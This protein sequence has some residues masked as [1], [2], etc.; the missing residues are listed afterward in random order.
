MATWKEQQGD[1]AGIDV[2]LGSLGDSVTGLVITVD[3][4]KRDSEQ[5]ILIGCS[6][7]E[8][9]RICE[10][11]NTNSQRATLLWRATNE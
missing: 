6:T 2:W 1:G 3:L 5:K 8:A 10:F 9:Q 4:H 11:H 7:D